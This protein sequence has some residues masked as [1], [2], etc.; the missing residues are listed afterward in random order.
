MISW[1]FFWGILASE[2]EFSKKNQDITQKKKI[3]CNITFSYSAQIAPILEGKKRANTAKN[4]LQ[5]K[6]GYYSVF[7]VEIGEFFKFAKL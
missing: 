2:A 3:S 6:S 5:K 7:L 1:F 4:D